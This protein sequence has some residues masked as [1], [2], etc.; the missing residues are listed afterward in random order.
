MCRLQLA[1]LELGN[2]IYELHTS[3]PT[4]QRPPLPFFVAKQHPRSQRIRL[5]YSFKTTVDLPLDY[6]EKHKKDQNAIGTNAEDDDDP[7]TKGS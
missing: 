6:I 2:R 4:A 7:S 5:S 1:A 3:S